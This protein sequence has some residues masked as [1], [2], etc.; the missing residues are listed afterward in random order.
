MNYTVI[1]QRE[2]GFST[3]YSKTSLIEAIEFVGKINGDGKS[4]MSAFI[5][6]PDEFM[7]ENDRVYIDIHVLIHVLNQ[8]MMVYDNGKWTIPKKGDNTR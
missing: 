5:L 3:P 7:K 2:N 6:S 4:P 8:P 1:V